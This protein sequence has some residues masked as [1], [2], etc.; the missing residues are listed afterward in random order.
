MKNNIEYPKYHKE[1]FT[2][3]NC[4]AYSKQEWNDRVV[5]SD[6]TIYNTNQKSNFSVCRCQH[7]GYLSFWYLEKLAWPLNSSVESPL[8][9]MPDDIKD[10][11]N[12]A[13]SIIE[14]SPKGACAIIR[15]ALQK[16]CNRLA[17]QDE[18]KKIDGAIK[19]LVENGL[20]TSLQKAMDSIRIVGDEAVHPGVINIDDNKEL[21][22]AMFRMMNIIVEKMILEP[23]EID[24]LYQLM[25]ENKIEGIK[26]R[27]KKNVEAK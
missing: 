4:N 6:G 12:E 15:L 24:E 26:N 10:L 17:G 20:P 1:A 2:C 18:K 21:A 16:L 25:P 8:E 7:C 13:R 19:K 3:V 5:S 23:K 11:Y 22:I 27:D 14:L 9:E